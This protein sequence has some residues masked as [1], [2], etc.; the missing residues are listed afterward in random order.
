MTY[1]GLISFGIVL[2]TVFTGIAFT[3]IVTRR[4]TPEEFGTWS[5]IGSLIV[6]V[7]VLDPIST[8]WATRQVARKE[9]VA[10]TALGSSI[11][12]SIVGVGLYLV[13]IYFMANATDAD[14]NVLLFSSLM[15]PLLYINKAMRSILVGY[16]PQGSSYGLLIFEV[17]KIPLGLVLVYW[18]DMGIIGAIITTVLAQSASIIFY[19][20]YM[21]EKLREKFYI[22]ELKKWLKRF[23]IPLIQGNTD[24]L[25]HLD[26]TIYSVIVGSVTGL[27]FLGASKAIV[28]AI[29]MTVYLSSGLYPKLIA[30]Q[31]SDYIVMV[32]KRTLLFTIPIVGLT[33]IFAKPGLWIINPL[34]LEGVILVYAWAFIQFAYVIETILTSSL[35]GLETVDT[36]ENPKLKQF[37]KSKL[38][39]VPAIDTTGRI[40]YLISLVTVL[41]FLFQSNVPDVEMIFWWGIIGIISNIVIISLYWRMIKKSISF[42][43][44][45]KNISKYIVTTIISSIPTYLFIENYLVYKESI[46]D[47]IPEI[48]PYLIFYVSIYISII[49]LWD[50]ETRQFLK[51]IIDELRK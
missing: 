44:P 36:E 2:L 6:L 39:K 38:F 37:L 20:F 31:K 47:F 45:I 51:S 4:L 9:E 34:Y 33:I 27:A 25:I 30:L 13:I 50:R 24:R 18:L 21:R 22:N 40:I 17:I 10:V 12:F 5:L 46:F 49:Y 29:S 7:M 35:L 19:L 1:S 15:I 16:K 23:W 3:I 8:Y 26:V 14:Y 32:F 28:N 43:L 48:I 42:D 11:I 41:P